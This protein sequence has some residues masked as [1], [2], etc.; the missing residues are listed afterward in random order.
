M[1]VDKALSK[2]QRIDAEELLQQKYQGA[3]NA[4]VPMLLDNGL[5]WQSIT[6]NPDDAQMLESRGFSVEE[7][8]RFFGV[9]PHMV[10]HTDNSTSWGTGLEQQTLG[11][12]KFTLRRRLKRIE[13]ALEK[14]LLTARDR[15]DGIT[16]EFN[17]EGLLRA[18]S[19]ARSA[20]Y[21][22]MTRIGVMTINE[23]R[24]LE[25]LPPVEGGD[26][27]RMQMQNVP[28]TEAQ[29]LNGGGNAAA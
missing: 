21:G 28:I 25:N 22:N 3:M 8:C 17:L 24:A 9:P 26:V 1:S 13:Q 15:A 12:Q 5:T 14:Q 7:I 18:D 19:A 2:Q 29:G 23:V 20:F 16:V 6:I 11:F 10:G 4:G 27:P